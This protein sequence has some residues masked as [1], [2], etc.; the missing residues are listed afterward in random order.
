MLPEIV[1]GYDAFSG[2]VWV[3]L[4]NTGR[5][6]CPFT[7][8]ANA[9]FTN[10]PWTASVPPMGEVIQ[11]WALPN[12]GNWYDFTVSSPAAPG[13]TRRFA[14]RVETKKPS[15]SDPAMGGPAIGDRLQVGAT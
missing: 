11:R 5:D 7:I 8:A 1:V 10:G 4:H 13:F 2:G 3:K 12:S 15:I 9:Y 14:G 6:A